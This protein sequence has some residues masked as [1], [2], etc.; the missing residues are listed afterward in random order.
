MIDYRETLVTILHSSSK[1]EA[2]RTLNISVASLSYRVSQM[3]KAGVK[4]PTPP[5]KRVLDNLLVAQLNSLIKKY[6]S[7]EE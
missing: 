1:Q 2:A 4:V 7:S 3:K 6:K 5:R